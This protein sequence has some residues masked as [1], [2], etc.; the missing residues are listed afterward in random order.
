MKK[1]LKRLKTLASKVLNAQMDAA[2]YVR[3]IIDEYNISLIRKNL[4]KSK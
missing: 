1:S 3:K 2:V 4:K